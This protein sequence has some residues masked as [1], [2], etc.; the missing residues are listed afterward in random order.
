[1]SSTTLLEKVT[2]INQDLIDM[3][4]DSADIKTFWEDCIAAAEMIQIAKDNEI[5]IINLSSLFQQLKNMKEGD[6]FKIKGEHTGTWELYTENEGYF[7]IRQT[8]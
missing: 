6:Y 5:P 1:M 7:F 4:F 3:G 8:A 2:H